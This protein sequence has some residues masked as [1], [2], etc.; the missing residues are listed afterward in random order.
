MISAIEVAPLMFSVIA[1]ILLMAPSAHA[2]MIGI[3]ASV[4]A[5]A[6]FVPQAVRVWRVRNDA[7]ALGGVSVVTNMFIINNSIVW[8][9]YAASIGEF[10]VGAAGI[11][12]LP[13]ASL[14]VAVILRSRLK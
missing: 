12:N 2:E 4:L 13:L 8:G 6:V 7:H 9:L 14:I 5:F 1:A 10:F 3:M 11:V